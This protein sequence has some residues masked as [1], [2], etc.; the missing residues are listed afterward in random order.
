MDNKVYSSSGILTIEGVN[1]QV[2]VFDISGRLIQQAKISGTFNS[3]K[4]NRGLYILRVDG[5]TSK[6][7]VQ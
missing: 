4:L 2:E 6:T 1:A 5:K 7:M 3:E